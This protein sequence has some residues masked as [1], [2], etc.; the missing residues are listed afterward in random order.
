MPAAAYLDRVIAENIRS[1]FLENA[2]VMSIPMDQWMKLGAAANPTSAFKQKI[3]NTYLKNDENP[4]MY[5]SNNQYTFRNGVRKFL[6][7]L[8]KYLPQPPAST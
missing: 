3:Y 7:Y 1:G 8:I 6:T 2:A 4:L 5:I